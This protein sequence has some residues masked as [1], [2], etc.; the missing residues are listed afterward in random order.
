MLANTLPHDP[1]RRGWSASGPAAPYHAAH[2]PVFPKPIIKGIDPADGPE[3][4]RQPGDIVG[5]VLPRPETGI[6][7]GRSGQAA[8]LSPS[9]FK[10]ANRIEGFTPPDRAPAGRAVTTGQ[11]CSRTRQGSGGE[12]ASLRGGLPALT[13]AAVHEAAAQA[14][15]AGA[16]RVGGAASPSRATGRCASARAALRGALE[17]NELTVAKQVA[18]YAS[19]HIDNLLSILRVDARIFDLTRSGQDEAPSP[20]ALLKFLQLVYHQSDDFCAVAMFDEH[21]TLVGQPAY[22]ETRARYEAL[23]A[24]TRRCAPPTS[25]ASG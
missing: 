9:Y 3:R 6:W 5:Q 24:T 12:P 14:D 13:K 10:S 1:G 7:F 25:R 20:Q 17:E 15:V 22:L 23:Q 8:R 4:R 18:G 11:G 16:R 2:V 19:S 21:G